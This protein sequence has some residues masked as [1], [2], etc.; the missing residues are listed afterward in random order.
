MNT[1]EM[2]TDIDALQMLAAEE[3]LHFGGNAT[4][5][6]SFTCAVTTCSETVVD[7]D[8]PLGVRPVDVMQA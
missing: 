5:S 6:P 4:C 1:Q 3:V 2:V 8:G 7:S